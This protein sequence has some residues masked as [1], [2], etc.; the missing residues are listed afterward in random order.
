MAQYTYILDR[1]PGVTIMGY[2]LR[3]H[4]Q[5]RAWLTDL[6]DAEPEQARLVGEAILALI[7]AG[8]ALGPPLVVSLESVL[9]QPEDPRETLDR[10]YQ[11]QLERL[12]QVRRGVA[13][14]ATSRK[15]VE[16]QIVSLEQQA[17]RL[18]RQREEA[19][20]AGRE[21]LADVA[22]GRAA[23]VVGQLSGLRRQYLR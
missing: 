9:G 4:G 15:R 2:Q 8:E 3:L 13:D 22:A 10:S 14:V 23:A 21:D 16:L 20:R 5:I 6:R 11:R 19:E 17:D 7:D 1:G 12:T 18:V